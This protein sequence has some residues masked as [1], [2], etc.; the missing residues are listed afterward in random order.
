MLIRRNKWSAARVALATL[1]VGGTAGFAAH[2][3]EGFRDHGRHG[4]G[5]H[6]RAVLCGAEHG[7]A[8]IREHR[9]DVAAFV[10]VRLGLDGTQRALLDDLLRQAETVALELRAQCPAA[11]VTPDALAFLDRGEAALATSLEGLRRL[12]PAFETF[13]AAL[14]G[15]QRAH[16][17]RW[18]AHR[19][20]RRV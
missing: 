18:L 2:A 1:V 15:E 6:H 5:R 20:G 3:A 17:E 4:W 8:A 7:A 16:V 11:D 19:H 10:T 9:D 12:R 14:D 13:L